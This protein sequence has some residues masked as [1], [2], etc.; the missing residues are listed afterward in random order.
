MQTLTAYYSLYAPLIALPACFIAVVLAYRME[1]VRKRATFAEAQLAAAQDLRQQIE[2]V[3]DGYIQRYDAEKTQHIDIKTQLAAR[4]QELEGLKGQMADWGKVKEEHLQAA[5]A[6]LYNTAK[7]LNAQLLEE[8][9]KESQQSKEENQKRVFESM[10]KFNEQFLKVTSQL[11]LLTRDVDTVK[12]VKEALLSPSGAGSLGEITLENLLNASMLR[13]ESD[14]FLQPSFTTFEKRR[15]KPDAILSL[16]GNHLMIVDSKASKFFMEIHAAGDDSILKETS[17]GKLKDR[18]LEHLRTL[19]QRDYLDALQELGD[20]NPYMKGTVQA[21]TMVMF[22]PSDAALETLRA[23]EPKIY[24]KAMAD[25]I[26]L[27]GP[28]GMI[29]MLMHAHIVVNR[30]KEQE[31]FNIIQVEVKKLLKNLH[32]L[33]SH[34]EKLAISLKPALERL[35][36]FSRSYNRYIVSSANRLSDL[37]VIGKEDRLKRLERYELDQKT[38]EDVDYREENDLAGEKLLAFEA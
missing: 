6:S 34:A 27:V 35:D 30:V 23:L 17:E 13:V 21:L 37:G 5:Q 15:L 24:E 36:G 38:L 2:A 8:H 4:I 3:R 20:A 14:Y 19:K 33:H 31:N 1:M 9:K 7:Q 29:N 28:A 16:P 25:N 32:S 26:I 12:V 18:M 10:E 22:I 11:T